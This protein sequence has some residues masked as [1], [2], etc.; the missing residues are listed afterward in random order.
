MWCLVDDVSWLPAYLSIKSS[1]GAAGIVK[2]MYRVYEAPPGESHQWNSGTDSRGH[3]QREGRSSCSRRPFSRGSSCTYTPRMEI[4]LLAAVILPNSE[5]FTVPNQT[6]SRSGPSFLASLGKYPGHF[7]V[8]FDFMLF[9]SHSAFILKI[10]TKVIVLWFIIS[11]PMLLLIN[12]YIYFP[13]CL[14]I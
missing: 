12:T 10:P 9:N 5:D 6:P 7:Y 13:T 2:H 1:M 4:L 3:Q 8:E 14:A 11:M